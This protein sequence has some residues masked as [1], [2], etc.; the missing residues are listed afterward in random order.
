MFSEFIEFK[1]GA[2]YIFTDCL[3]LKT[4]VDVVTKLVSQVHAWAHR[5]TLGLYISEEGHR[6]VEGGEVFFTLFYAKHRALF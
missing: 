5:W 6:K 2:L 1:T 4:S 3:Y